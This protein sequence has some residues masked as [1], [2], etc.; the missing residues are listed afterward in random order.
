MAAEIYSDSFSIEGVDPLTLLIRSAGHPDAAGLLREGLDS[1]AMAP[2]T[3]WLGGARAPERAIVLVGLFIGT[4]LLRKV[5]KSRSLA[6]PDLDAIIVTLGHAM[7]HVV[8]DDAEIPA[9]INPDGD[10]PDL[11]RTVFGAEPVSQDEGG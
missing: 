6:E 5:I 7:Q 2:I 11:S 9:W 4:E 1:Q 8:D 10:D 3:E